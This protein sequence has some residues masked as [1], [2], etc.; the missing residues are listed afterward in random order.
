MMQ[1]IGTD[2]EH[3]NEFSS[4]QPE[5]KEI[6]L[7]FLNKQEEVIKDP[8][9]IISGEIDTTQE[10]GENDDETKD[11]DEIVNHEDESIEE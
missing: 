11:D 10:S 3:V 4:L 9:S 7:D 1:K 8:S 5:S 6:E 2:K